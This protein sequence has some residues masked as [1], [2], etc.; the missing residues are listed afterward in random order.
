MEFLKIVLLNFHLC[1]W[2]FRWRGEYIWHTF[3]GDSGLG[4][5]Q[6]IFSLQVSGTHF[7]AVKWA[8][9]QRHCSD[10]LLCFVLFY[11]SFIALVLNFI[12]LVWRLWQACKFAQVWKLKK[13][14]QISEIRALDEKKIFSM[15]YSLQSKLQVS[16]SNFMYNSLFLMYH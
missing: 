5:G 15:Q 12:S 8:R 6:S 14:N 7:R 10:F 13:Y 3:L 11:V 1:Y 16:T 2:L 9:W 4:R